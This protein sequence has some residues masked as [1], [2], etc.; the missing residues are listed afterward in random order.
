MSQADTCEKN[1]GSSAENILDIEAIEAMI[2]KVK[3]L[4]VP[5]PTFTTKG[6]ARRTLEPD[7]VTYTVGIQG[8]GEGRRA[9]LDDFGKELEKF[10]GC[11]GDEAVS[12]MSGLNETL[13]CRDDDSAT[14]EERP[15]EVGQTVISA[16]ATIR[17]SPG[18]FG[19]M[20]VALAEEGFTVSDP[21]F[22][23]GQ[24]TGPGADLYEE[25]AQTARD[26]AEGVAKGGRF[27][28]G[29][30]VHVSFGDG[31]TQE[32]LIPFKN[33]DWD[34]SPWTNRLELKTLSLMS[35]R[36]DRDVLPAVAPLGPLDPAVFQLLNTQVPVKT[37][38]VSVNLE[39]EFLPAA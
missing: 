37:I 25:A 36:K 3:D 6:T 16:T 12:S 7:G 33:L 10:K 2:E 11:L 14:S 5:D 32:K 18:A 26:I 23:F 35:W 20:F 39:V 21:A 15:Q 8:S 19:E 28:I 9:A 22:T 1:S 13:S 17:V 27:K 31:Q 30:V 29:N 24:D 4:H 34:N 38:S